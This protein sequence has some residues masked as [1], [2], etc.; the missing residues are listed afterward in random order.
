MLSV[1]DFIYTAPPTLDWTIQKTPNANEWNSVTFG[2]GTFVAVGPS[3]NGD[4]VMYSND[5][6]SWKAATGIVDN[7]WKS[8]AFGNGTFV[9]VSPTGSGNRVMYSKDG[10]NWSLANKTEDAVWGWVKFGNGKFVISSSGAANR[11]TNLPT[12]MYSS[13]GISWQN[14]TVTFTSNYSLPSQSISSLGFGGGLFVITGTPG[15]SALGWVPMLLTSQDGATWKWQRDFYGTPGEVRSQSYGC[16]NWIA[17]RPQSG[18]FATTVAERWS[19]G[20]PGSTK[21]FSS[22]TFAGGLFVAV[23]NGVSAQSNNATAWQDQMLTSQNNWSS[24]TYGNGIFVAVARSG[25]DSRVMT[26]PFTPLSL[27]KTSETVALGSSIQGSAS[28]FSS[29]TTPTYSISPSVEGTGLIFNAATGELSGKPLTSA[30]AGVYTISAN[31]ESEVSVSAQY[32]LTITNQLPTSGGGTTGSGNNSGSNPVPTAPSE[33]ANPQTPV[34]SLPKPETSTPVIVVPTPETSTPVI[35]VPTPTETTTVTAPPVV[36]GGPLEST[37]RLNVYFDM[38]S[39]KVYGSNLSKLQDLATK[40]SGLGKEIT[41]S[42]TGYAQ[43]TPG[44][45]ATDGKLSEDRAAAVAKIL[46]QFGVTTKVIYK[47]A[48]RATL[49]VPSSRYVEIVAANS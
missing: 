19:G 25:S 17:T 43:P 42:I 22:A 26:A 13:D 10:V 44:S 23:G 5:G 8:V 12:L 35:V 40:L 7:P 31:D 48:G 14:S 49:N 47:G 36:K 9:A 29:C 6:K 32:T 15:R 37:L 2:N 4:G 18:F 46:R 30:V 38:G 41:I 11:R 28:K 21:F 33:N 20:D 3:T 16:K 39:S 24:V 45:E 27:S 34:T 1:P